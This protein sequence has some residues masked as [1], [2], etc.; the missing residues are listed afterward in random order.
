M[1]SKSDVTAT[2]LFRFRILL[3]LES[4]KL[5]TD[6]EY[7]CRS[8]CACAKRLTSNYVVHAVQKLKNGKDFYFTLMSLILFPSHFLRLKLYY[9]QDMTLTRVTTGKKMTTELE[10]L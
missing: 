8:I 4:R 10:A 3:R 6:S 9:Q 2:A 5:N 1:T 7:T